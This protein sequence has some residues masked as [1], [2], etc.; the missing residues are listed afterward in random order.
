MAAGRTTGIESGGVE[1]RSPHVVRL[2]SFIVRD[3]VGLGTVIKRVTTRV[4]IAPCSPCERRTARLDSL[5]TFRPR[6]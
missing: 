3:S 5:I 2:P 1:S 4:G 6:L